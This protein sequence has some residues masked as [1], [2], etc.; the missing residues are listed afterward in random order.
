[1]LLFVVRSAPARRIDVDVSTLTRSVMVDA[2]I[3]EAARFWSRYGVDVKA[4]RDDGVARERAIRL[5][6]TIASPKASGFDVLGSI[7]F[8]GESA[9]PEITLYPALV[10]QLVSE[11]SR[12][13]C[14]CEWP[15]A[16]R[17]HLETRAL[18]RALAHEI[19]HYLLQSK[20]HARFG[21]M[22]ARHQVRDLMVPEQRHLLLTVDEI[23]RLD[24]LWT[25]RSAT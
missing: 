5:A 2:A 19:G 15:T 18:G 25:E 21:L 24:A 16:L 14:Q 10:A 4:V 8:E 17:K 22:R 23:Q 7:A 1:L 9:D 3:D 13:R 20:G 11:E 6:V 12:R